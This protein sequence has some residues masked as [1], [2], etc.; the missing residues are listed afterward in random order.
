[1]IPIAAGTAGRAAVAVT[2]LPE[3]GLIHRLTRGRAWIGVLGVLLIG[4]VALNVVT[5]S[6]T[7]SAG[8]VDERIQAL[9]RENSVLGSLQAKK[10]G[11]VQIDGKAKKLGLSA[12]T[13]AEPRVATVG[14]G[15][16]A[17]AA[18]RLAAAAAGT[19][20]ATSEGEASASEA[21]ATGEEAISG[22]EAVSGEEAGA[23][24]L[25]GLSQEEKNAIYAETLAKEAAE[26]EGEPVS[27]EEP[28][29]EVPTE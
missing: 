8:K 21:T 28:V 20:A 3:S 19:A 24:E 2:Q 1:V 15:N 9:S 18:A 10:Y 12:S 25:A 26:A 14:K 23:V 7:A 27:Y 6:F 22:E 13:A 17:A 29:T 4:I 16:V 5:L 11:Q